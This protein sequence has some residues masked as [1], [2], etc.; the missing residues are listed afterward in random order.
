MTTTAKDLLTRLDWALKA[1]HKPKRALCA[2]LGLDENLIDEPRSDTMHNSR[3]RR[4]GDTRAIKSLAARDEAGE[5]LDATSII[6]FLEDAVEDMPPEE[7][8]EL[9]DQ[10][11]ERL[12]ADEP[13]A[14]D[15]RRRRRAEDS[16]AGR[17]SRHRLGRDE[18]PPFGGRPNPGGTM[19]PLDTRASDRVAS[20][21]QLHGMDSA[22][23]SF[24]SLFPDARHIVISG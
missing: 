14:F 16:R 22:I 24:D 20:R 5:P 10:I 2:A 15:R 9:C 4:P 6:E 18:P 13:G 21:R 19:D 17:R 3:P 7:V 23:K 11:E 1:G 12:L 8:E